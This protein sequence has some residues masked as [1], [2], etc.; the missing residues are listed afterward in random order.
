MPSITP[1]PQ[2]G[3]API[4]PRETQPARETV[5]VASRMPVPSGAG[6]ERVA[7][8]GDYI[9]LGVGLA[10]VGVLAT[11]AVGGEGVAL[12]AA[13]LAKNAVTAAKA[14]GP[15]IAEEWKA[16][17]DG[18]KDAAGVGTF[19]AEQTTAAVADWSRSAIIGTG[20]SAGAALAQRAAHALAPHPDR[21]PASQCSPHP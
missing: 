7:G 14:F 10:G 18:L 2:S 3:A 11:A 5:P 20:L 1:A 12:G 21:T 16:S 15:K 17:A 13:A 19:A 8:L 4:P 6:R 9:T